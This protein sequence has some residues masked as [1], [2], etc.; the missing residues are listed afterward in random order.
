[1]RVDHGDLPASQVEDEGLLQFML[2][3]QEDEEEKG[4]GLRGTSGTVQPTG[5]GVADR[6]QRDKTER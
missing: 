2:Q 1:M 3:Q 6:S 4:H 5:S